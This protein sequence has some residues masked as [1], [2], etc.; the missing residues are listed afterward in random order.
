MSYQFGNI[1]SYIETPMTLQIKKMPTAVPHVPLPIGTETRLSVET[2]DVQ[3]S[4]MGES[5][6]L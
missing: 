3:R 2:T 6:R 5:I 4:Q 1:E